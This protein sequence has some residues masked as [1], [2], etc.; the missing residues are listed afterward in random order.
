MDNRKLPAWALW[1]LGATQVIGYG[2]LYYAFSVLVPDIAGDIG[3][4]EQWVFG[5]FSVALFVGSIASPVAGHLAD[6]FGSGRLMAVGSILTVLSLTALAFS[7]G[8]ITFALALAVTEIVSTAVLYAVAFTAIVQAGGR[9]AQKSIVHLTLIGGFA[10]S[11][12]WPL[13]SWLHG[14]LSWREVYLLFAALNLLIC[15]PV[16]YALG[17]LTSK[18]ITETKA[19]AVAVDERRP[20][21]GGTLVFTLML[22]GFAIE[23]YALSAILVHMVPLTQALGLGAAGLVVASLFGPAQVAS[24]LINLVFGKELSQKWL[25]VI[26]TILLPIGLIILLVTTPWGPGAVLFAICFGLGSGLTSIVGGTLP[27]ELFGREGYG[28]RLG[29]CTSAKQVTSAIAPLAMSVSLGGLGVVP[30]LWIAV[31]I[32]AA[33]TVA[34]LAI[35]FVT[36]AAPRRV[37]TATG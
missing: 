24:R 4:S 18:A 36:A 11:L 33:G 2:T 22:M 21:I 37:L 12:F 13:T 23:G 29:W 9:T 19:K 8:P 10:S 5:A 26:A 25:A 7:T 17:R 32:G 35:V 27:L 30:S 28:G 16:H 34:F 3:R 14:L 31:A 6:R 15:F 20:A 1:G